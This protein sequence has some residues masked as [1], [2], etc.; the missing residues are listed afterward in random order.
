MALRVCA[1]LGGDQG[2]VGGDHRP[3]AFVHGIGRQFGQVFADQRLASG[4]QQ[5]GCAESGQ[6]VDERFTFGGVQF[7]TGGTFG[8]M[9]RNSERILNCTPG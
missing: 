5:H 2:A 7:V 1:I 3:H 4:K 9:G 8:G 6:V